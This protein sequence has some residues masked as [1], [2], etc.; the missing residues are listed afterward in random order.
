[1]TPPG[2]E[3]LR[4]AREDGNGK[5]PHRHA[6][7]EPSPRRRGRASSAAHCKATGSWARAARARGWRG[8]F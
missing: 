7:A 2:A 8:K 1:M 5:S 3:I 6:R 4:C